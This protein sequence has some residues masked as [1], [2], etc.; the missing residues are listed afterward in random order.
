MENV[1]ESKNPEVLESRA[2]VEEYEL[3][4]VSLANAATQKPKAKKNINW[5]KVGV[6]GTLAC[7]VLSLGLSCAALIKKSHDNKNSNDQSSN[8]NHGSSYS[9]SSDGYLVIDGVKT[10]VKI[11]S[12]SDIIDA[13]IVPVDKWGISTFIKFTFDDGSYM[14]TQ[15]KQ[16]LMNDHY[17][18]AANA[19]DLQTLTATYGAP[20][21]RLT[22]HINVTS[23]FEIDSD[24]EINLNNK[25]IMYTA[26]S[27]I[28]V[29]DNTAVKFTN[30][31]LT[32]NAQKGLKLGNSASL[33]LTDTTVQAQG[34]IA[35]VVGNNAKVEIVDSSISSTGKVVDVAET[36]DKF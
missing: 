31:N 14:T 29:A 32:F 5:I 12:T 33:E 34:T 35:E 25:T 10:E 8:V 17:Y 36:A 1:N 26:T 23:S 28:S 21:V 15:P 20:K 24:V 2:A 30:G 9:V 19:E 22:S 27:P 16:Q 4:E 6:A 3:A 7:S 18:D 11:G 13:E